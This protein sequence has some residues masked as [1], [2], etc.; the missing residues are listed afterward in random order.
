MP[1]DT[2]VLLA[3]ESQA[4]LDDIPIDSL[5][6]TL[7]RAKCGGRSCH[8]YVQSWA[9]WIEETGCSQEIPSHPDWYT[10]YSLLTPLGEIFLEYLRARSRAMGGNPRLYRQ[11]PVTFR[12][13][14]EGRRFD[15]ALGPPDAYAIDRDIRHLAVNRPEI[16]RITCPI[17]RRQW[18]RHGKVF[19]EQ[20]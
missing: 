13:F 3:L 2:E 20:V 14:L 4:A 7:R 18:V 6:A 1:V 9:H 15:V 19:V 12:L 17:L 11:G 5:I 8:N 16:V 10:P